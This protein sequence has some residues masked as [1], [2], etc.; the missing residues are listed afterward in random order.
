MNRTLIICIK[1]FFVGTRSA[2]SLPSDCP[3]SSDFNNKKVYLLCP[4]GT[5]ATSEK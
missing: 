3:A 4:A 2:V 5:A 1:P